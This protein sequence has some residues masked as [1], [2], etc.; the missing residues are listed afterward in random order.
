MGIQATG[1]MYV[2]SL[3]VK[4]TI[5]LLLLLLVHNSGTQVC[6]CF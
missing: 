6:H 4:P 1:N 3:T 5:Q 2:R